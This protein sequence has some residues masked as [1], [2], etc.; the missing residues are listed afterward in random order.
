[1]ASLLITGA[2]NAQTVFINE[3]HYDNLGADALEGV[4]IAGPAG[5]DLSTYAIYLYNGNNG[6]SYGANNPE[7]LT[8]TITDQSGC[9]YGTIWFPIAGIQ[10]GAPD[11]IALVEGGTN[12][13]QFLS[14][15][16][17]FTAGD[18]PAMTMTST[19]IGVMESGSEVDSSLQLIG[20]G[21]VYT[22]FSW[23]TPIDK[24]EGAINTGQNFC[25]AAS[26]S[27]SFAAASS[28]YNEADGTVTVSLNI[29]P[30]TAAAETVEITVTDV[31]A[32]YGADY[33]TAPAGVTPFTLNIGA[34]VT[35]VSFDVVLTDDAVLET[36]EDVEFSISNTSAGLGTGGVTTHTMTITDNDDPILPIATVQATTT[37]DFSDLEGTSVKV[38]GIVSAVKS[39]NGFFIQDGVGAWNGIYVYDAGSNTVARGDSVVLTGTVAEFAPG[40]ST[41]K[42]T[43]ITN[44]TFFS[45]IG[46]NTPY[47]AESVTTLAVNDEMYEG[48]LI[49]VST[50]L[51]ETVPDG[52]GEWKVND[53]SGTATCDDFLY[54]V[55]PTPIVGNVY[56]L[57]G[58]MG[59]S[60]DFYKI[61]PRDAADVTLLAGASVNE[62]AKNNFKVYPNPSNGVINFSNTNNETVVI[63]NSLGQVVATTT[64]SSIELNSGVYLV[65][66]GNSISRV[67]VK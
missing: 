32:T 43:Q 15:E 42:A 64:Q 29:S 54:V 9:G 37:G 12:V 33:T 53:G 27:V 51:T 39:G 30:A 35:S 66:L 38:T 57:T 59:H 24:T 60:F 55:T 6:L 23:S 25:A 41:T 62:V 34:G 7:P 14:Y 50:V 61:M 21:T 58:V 11:G 46:A 5:T 52:F 1:M 40:A 36:A 45:N 49:T 8:G 13:I 18:G 3:I 67:V 65:R 56:N 28:T 2:L 22:D 44:L 63:Y 47:A 48:V 26:P 17:S 16:G 4:E 10:N 31:T 19:D 20:N